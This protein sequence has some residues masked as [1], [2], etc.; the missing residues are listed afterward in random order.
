MD[1][2]EK[3]AAMP[4]G[5]S[6]AE[7]FAL[8]LAAEIS[9][10]PAIGRRSVCLYR[11]ELQSGLRRCNRERLRRGLPSIDADR[12]S[13]LLAH[14]RH[15]G[16]QQRHEGRHAAHRFVRPLLVQCIQSFVCQIRAAVVESKFHLFSTL[17][18]APLLR[19]WSHALDRARVDA[20][21][22]GFFGHLDYCEAHTSLVLEETQEA[23]AVRHQ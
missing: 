2:I 8:R 11:N 7:A 19:I 16:A 5:Q 14:S 17:I 4:N 18:R 1:P 23:M 12:F 20:W 22:D 10:Q 9:P 13:F 15:P 6:A 3:E 21:S